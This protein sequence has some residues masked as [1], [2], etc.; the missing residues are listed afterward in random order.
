MLIGIVFI[1][2]A[3]LL[4]AGNIILDLQARRIHRRNDAVAEFRKEI[5]RM[6]SEES[7]RRIHANREDYL[8]PYDIM[9]RYSYVQMFDSDKPL[10]LEA[11]FT[12]E[13]IKILKGK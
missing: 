5:L 8:V 13:E 12:E 2:A 3:I 9:D 1:A 6:A 4:I 10:N 11:W 7:K